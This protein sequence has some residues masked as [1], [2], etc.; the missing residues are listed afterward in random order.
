MAKNSVKVKMVSVNLQVV[1]QSEDKSLHIAEYPFYPQ[2]E[3]FETAKAKAI[4]SIGSDS[5]VIKFVK[6]KKTVRTYE[7]PLADII[8]SFG[9][10]A[11]YEMSE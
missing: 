10:I 6:G 7:I 1:W 9:T 5:K 11:R 8:D 2:I 4:A 3:E